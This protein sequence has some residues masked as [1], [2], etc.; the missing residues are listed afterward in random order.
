MVLDQIA[1]FLINRE[2]I[3]GK[4]FMQI[5]RKVLNRPR[6]PNRSHLDLS[7]IQNIESLETLAMGAGAFGLYKQLLCRAVLLGPSSI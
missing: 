1:D 6:F 5:L 2:T 7:L 3:T 4:E